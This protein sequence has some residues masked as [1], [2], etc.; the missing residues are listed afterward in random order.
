[1]RVIDVEQASCSA[2][3]TGGDVFRTMTRTATGDADM[4]RTT[5]EA[6]KGAV[7]FQRMDEPGHAVQVIAARGSPP[8]LEFHENGARGLRA[9]ST[10]PLG[11]ARG[12]LSNRALIARKVESGAL[13]SGVVAS[14][15]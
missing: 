13:R 8:S 4:E 7:S 15:A 2:F 10:A 3:E 11:A 14:R 1:M 12:V 6:G 5:I 9:R